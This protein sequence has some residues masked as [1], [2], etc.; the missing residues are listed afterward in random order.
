MIKTK[1]QTLASVPHKKQ[2]EIRLDIQKYLRGENKLKMKDIHEKHD[3]TA[4]ITQKLMR[5]EIGIDTKH[6][7]L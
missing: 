1:I 3:V 4:Y 7:Q 2:S 5:M 6:S